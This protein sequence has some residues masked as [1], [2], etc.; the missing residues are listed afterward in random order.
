MGLLKKSIHSLFN[1]FG[2]DVIKTGHFDQSLGS[3]LLKVFSSRQIDCV[4]D[5]G[6]NTGQY[7]RFLRD[8]GYAGHIVSFE[9]VR[10]VYAEL[11]K[12]A[13]TDSMWTC[14][15]VALSDMP[16]EK[17]INVFSD[18]QFCSFLEVSDYAKSNWLELK[19]ATTE[20]VNVT[21]LD[22]VFESIKAKTQCRNYYLKLDTQGFDLNVFRGSLESRKHLRAMQ[23][24][25]ALIDVYASKEGAFEG[26]N[27]YRAAGFAVSG[28]FPIN[29]DY[30][31]S[32]IEYDCVM[33]K[34]EFAGSF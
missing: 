20:I 16:G 9:P 6:A 18:T 30:N 21:R 22:D 2:F 28:M 29:I 8:I 11:L 7:G 3:H 15:N 19:R 24:E 12:N 32:V 34:T 26:L 4:L 25:L 13:E 33:V 5:V 14:F 10:S 1:L 17:K 31:L 27:E 23:S